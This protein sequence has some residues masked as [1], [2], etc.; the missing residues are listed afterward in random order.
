[1]SANE[2]TPN[3]AWHCGGSNELL[4]IAAHAP[5]HGILIAR[6]GRA[7]TPTTWIVPTFTALLTGEPVP[8]GGRIAISA[9]DRPGFGELDRSLPLERPYPR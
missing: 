7:F 5:A 9:L 6:R 2:V 1:M 3:R 8:E 4:K